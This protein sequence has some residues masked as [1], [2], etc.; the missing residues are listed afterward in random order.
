MVLGLDVGEL[1]FSGWAHIL[2]KLATECIRMVL[3]NCSQMFTV[4][5]LTARWYYEKKYSWRYQYER[6]GITEIIIPG[7][8][9]AV[10][11]RE[12]PGKS[13]ML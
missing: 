8:N 6:D 7:N 10:L 13:R 2:S 5:L 3:T 11:F 9:I 1:C 4:M 12:R